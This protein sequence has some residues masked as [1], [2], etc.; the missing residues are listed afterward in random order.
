MDQQNGQ[1]AVKNAHVFVPV[2]LCAVTTL[3]F[4]IKRIISSEKWFKYVVTFFFFE[5]AKNLGRSDD[6]KRRKKREWPNV[7]KREEVSEAGQVLV[8]YDAGVL[9]GSYRY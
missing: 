5:N 6:S 1:Y 4:Q 7:D 9:S 8:E 2:V 3:I